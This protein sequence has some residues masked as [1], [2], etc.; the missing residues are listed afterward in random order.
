MNTINPTS[1]DD[2]A[3]PVTVQ[4][5]LP[6]RYLAA[7]VFIVGGVAL[8]AFLS[9]IGADLAA[10]FLLAFLLDIPARAL[11]KRTRLTYPKAAILIYLVI[12]VILAV[13]LI[14]G[15]KF[16]VQGTENILVDLKSGAENLL[17]T[18]GSMVNQTIL[19]VDNEVLSKIL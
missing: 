17:G 12:Y 2:E 10:G 19:G 11:A 8:L 1:S 3:S 16:F 6:A 14:V 7:G 9:P 5:S 13:L 4:W 18:L 15:F